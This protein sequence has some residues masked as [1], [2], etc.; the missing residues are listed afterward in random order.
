MS[1]SGHFADF[2]FIDLDA[3]ARSGQTANMAFLV[4]KDR[5]VGQVIEQIAALDRK[6]VV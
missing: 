3:Q 5:R 2:L 1:D 6:S 4:G